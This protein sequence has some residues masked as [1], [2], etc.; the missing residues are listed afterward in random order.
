MS[1][2]YSETVAYGIGPFFDAVDL[3]H[4]LASCSC[5]RAF[6]LHHLLSS[7]YKPTP[8]AATVLKIYTICSRRVF[9]RVGLQWCV[10][11]ATPPKLAGNGEPG[12][13]AIFS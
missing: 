7:H 9:I 6:D 13:L 10:S 1:I 4:L 12:V 3:H 8:S 11:T 2:R 5:R